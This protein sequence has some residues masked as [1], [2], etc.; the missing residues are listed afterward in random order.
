MPL[1]SMNSGSGPEFAVIGAVVKLLFLPISVVLLRAGFPFP[2]AFNRT[3]K[4][5]ASLRSWFHF[6][7]RA[8]SRE[9]RSSPQVDYGCVLTVIGL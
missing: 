2:R 5:E 6:S 1:T 9:S 7:D 3:K 4:H 8:V